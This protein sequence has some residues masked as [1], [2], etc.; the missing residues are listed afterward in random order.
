MQLLDESPL[1]QSLTSI[2]SLHSSTEGAINQLLEALNNEQ[3]VSSRLKVVRD[4][5]SRS[6][7][8]LN[9]LEGR[10]IFAD[11]YH[12]ENRLTEIR[13]SLRTLVGN[14]LSPVLIELEEFSK[15]Y[16]AFLRKPFYPEANSLL[17]SA[18]SLLMSIKTGRDLLAEL[19]EAVEPE[20]DIDERHETISL[21]LYSTLRYRDILTKMKALDVIYEELCHLMNVSPTVY[22]LKVIKIETGSLWLNLFGESRIVKLLISLMESAVIFLYRNYTNEGKLSYIPK[23]LE[24]IDSILSLSQKLEDYGIDSSTIKEN[25]QKSAVIISSQLNDLLLGEPTIKIN[26]VTHSIQQALQDKFL[27]ESRKLMLESGTEQEG[28]EKT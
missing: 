28:Q 17:T 9:N 11:L 22:P 20:R 14:S 23:K 6:I 27:A 7:G 5:L 12:F 10:K 8:Q 16:E 4:E 21:L 13:K 24:S 2:A 1:L 26:G 15:R 3:L 18:R 25:L 19:Q